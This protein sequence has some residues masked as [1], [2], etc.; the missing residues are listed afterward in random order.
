MITAQASNTIRE[1]A[2]GSLRNPDGQLSNLTSLEIIVATDV[3]LL[4]LFI[5]WIAHRGA[6]PKGWTHL[7]TKPLTASINYMDTV[8]DPVFSSRSR[9]IVRSF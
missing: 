8:A 7:V 4:T 1:N 6:V 9:N 3:K 5:L 2:S